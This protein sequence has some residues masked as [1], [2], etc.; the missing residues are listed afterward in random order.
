ME[1][2][3]NFLAYDAATGLFSWIQKPSK[4]IAIG[5]IA[6]HASKIGYIQIGFKGK[7]YLGHRIAWLLFYKENPPKY[8]DHINCNKGDNR[9]ENLRS[10][11]NAQNMSNMSKTKR[12]STGFKGV[13]FHKK[14][15]KYIASIGHKGK[16]IYIGLYNTPEEAHAAYC[17]EAKKLH[18]PYFCV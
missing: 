4:N 5:T 16:C 3:E 13:S 10:A 14:L 8:I 6:G 12:N 18:G 9:I 11:T 17:A 15:G 7:L 2:I 1:N